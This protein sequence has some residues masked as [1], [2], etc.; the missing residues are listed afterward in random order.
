MS[1]GMH[2][3]WVAQGRAFGAKQP[4]SGVGESTSA[5]NFGLTALKGP[6]RKK[7]PGARPIVQILKSAT[8]VANTFPSPNGSIRTIRAMPW[9][10][11]I[12][13]K[14]QILSSAL[15][16]AQLSQSHVEV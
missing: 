4:N 7:N 15:H 8:A 11:L 16:T 12:S 14:I 2:V 6:S 3:R 5:R 13:I 9:W 1:G 10:M